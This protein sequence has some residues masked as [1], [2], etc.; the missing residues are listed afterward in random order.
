MPFRFVLLQ[1]ALDLEIERLV[2]GGKALGQVLMDR[3]L[4]DPELLCRRADRGPVLYDVLSER[5][6][7]LLDEG[8]VVERIQPLRKV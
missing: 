1:H 3:G 6:G 8:P 4:A 7:T 2:E 5:D